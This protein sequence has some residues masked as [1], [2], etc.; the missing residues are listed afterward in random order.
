MMT[1]EG[2]GH[3]YGEDGDDSQGGK[4]H[5]HGYDDTSSLENHDRRQDHEDDVFLKEMTLTVLAVMMSSMTR[6][7]RSTLLALMTTQTTTN[8]EESDAC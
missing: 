1:N 8:D 7:F 2:D 4:T 5:G 3:G 6:T